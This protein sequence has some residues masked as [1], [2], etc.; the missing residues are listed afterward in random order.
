MVAYGS[1]VLAYIVSGSMVLAY[2]VSGSTV[3]AY[4]V[5]GSRV[6]AYLAGVPGVDEPGAVAA[7][8]VEVGVVGR[9]EG[10]VEVLQVLAARRDVTVDLIAQVLQPGG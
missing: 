1:T 4:L 9:A 10:A 2:L 3:L 7:G 5:S 8:R 6:L